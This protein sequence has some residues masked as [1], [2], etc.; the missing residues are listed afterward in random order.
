MRDLELEV[1]Q[2]IVEALCLTHV[3]A[4]DILTDEPLFVDGLGLDSIDALEL[5]LAIKKKFKVAFENQDQNMTS[6]FS[7][8]KSLA[9]YIRSQSGV[10]GVDSLSIN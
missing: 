7:S 4:E 6:Y 3:K 2:L 5:G 8:V 10:F 1:K 9:N